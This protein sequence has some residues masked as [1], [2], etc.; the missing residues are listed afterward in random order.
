MTV[1]SSASGDARP[2][3]ASSWEAPERYFTLARLG[4]GAYGIVYRVLDMALG[5][6]VAL[7]VLTPT[8][9]RG[10]DLYRFKREFRS[11]RDVVHPNLVR[12][13]E[14]VLIGEPWFFTM[15][16]VRGVTIR[17]HLAPAADPSVDHP[18]QPTLTGGTRP[19]RRATAPSDLDRTRDA[20]YQLADAVAAI[21]A[22]GKIHR[23]LKPS[24][25]L[26]DERGRVVVLD[27]GLISDDAHEPSADRT[28]EASAVGTPGYMSPEQVLDEPLSAA[29]DWYSVGVMLYEA[30]TGA[31]PFAGSRAEMMRRR[32]LESPP[33][34][35][36]LV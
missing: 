19:G 24:N 11:L 28:H 9:G 36:A 6:E 25:V 4:Q 15:E 27:F 2:A 23:D 32:T 20:F 18:S 16:L 30:L 3:V 26:V 33:P 10:V 35:R 13:Y 5:V 14:L 21:H 7:K 22:T 29:T 31:R 34:P 17:E 8:A 12:L 1:G